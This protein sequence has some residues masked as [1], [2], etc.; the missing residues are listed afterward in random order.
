MAHA[1]TEGE[2]VYPFPFGERSSPLGGRGGAAPTESTSAT[3]YS[4]WYLQALVL[5]IVAVPGYYRVVASVWGWVI[6]IRSN[7]VL[8]L[9]SGIRR[10]RSYARMRYAPPQH[11][12]PSSSHGGVYPCAPRNPGLEVFPSGNRLCVAHN[13]PPCAKRN[14]S[15]GWGCAS[16]SPK[17]KGWVYADKRIVCDIY[18]R[19]YAVIGCAM[20]HP[21]TY[22]QAH[23]STA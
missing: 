8:Y 9:P 21:I 12:S 16:R 22:P 3:P 14:P 19:V 6:V 7:C 23:R 20:H 1:L 18:G 11:L 13:P 15:L 4:G 10:D 2:R 17:G 5:G